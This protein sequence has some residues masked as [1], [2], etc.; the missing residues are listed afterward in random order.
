MVII[1]WLFSEC[2]WWGG[3]VERT[4]FR[5][6]GGSLSGIQHAAALRGRPDLGEGGVDG[7]MSALHHK[8]A[9]ALKRKLAR[10]NK[11]I[12]G[13]DRQAVG[14]VG[15]GGQGKRAPSC[16]TPNKE[17]QPDKTACTFSI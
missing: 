5:R 3:R 2:V 1:F 10:N 4:R 9:A 8:V 11:I 6:R 16:Q 13:A 14:G 7:A 17:A 15:V 12:R